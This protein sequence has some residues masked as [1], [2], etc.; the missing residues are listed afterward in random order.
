MCE[1]LNIKRGIERT[2]QGPAPGSRR[3]FSLSAGLLTRQG[4]ALFRPPLVSRYG[5]VGSRVP[6]TPPLARFFCPR[7]CHPSV[8]L[9]LSVV[10]WLTV[11]SYVLGA[12]LTSSLK[13]E[14][15]LAR[16]VW[17]ILW[18]M[19]GLDP[20]ALQGISGGGSLGRVVL[21]H[22]VHQVDGVFVGAGKERRE[23]FFVVFDRPSSR[24]FEWNTEA[25]MVSVRARG[26][27]RSRARGEDICRRCG[28]LVT[29]LPNALPQRL[30]ILPTSSS[31]LDV[32]FAQRAAARSAC[33]RQPSSWL[34]ASCLQH[35]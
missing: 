23:V 2:L 17:L 27:R 28:Q 24:L 13:V 32:H 18:V 35:R 9:N 31:S 21:K 26:F 16:C 6:C 12:E 34:V 4:A 33:Q 19:L 14:I 25:T 20:L 30:C 11:P 1:A 29:R 7:E 5:V 10:S 15:D 3:D 22:A 8:A